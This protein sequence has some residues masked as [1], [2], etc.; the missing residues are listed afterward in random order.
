MH[1]EI[2]SSVEGDVDAVAYIIQRKAFKRLHDLLL[3]DV[4]RSTLGRW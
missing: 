1:I 3:P 4:T 2:I